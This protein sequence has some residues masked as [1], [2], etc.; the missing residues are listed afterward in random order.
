MLIHR[1]TPVECKVAFAA[2]NG[3]RSPLRRRP[4]NGSCR[5]RVGATD[6]LI[7]WQV[8]ASNSEEAL[9]LL[10]AFIAERT[11]AIPVGEVRV[12]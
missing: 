2:W 6:H 4:T 1:H 3:F 5:T 9:A 12:P 7:C 10:P 11:E 8:D